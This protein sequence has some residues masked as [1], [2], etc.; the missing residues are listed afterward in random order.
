MSLS[1]SLH[2]AVGSEGHL[3]P[4][5]SLRMNLCKFLMQFSALS[6][7]AKIN[8]S[9]QQQSVIYIIEVS[10]SKC[11]HIMRGQFPEVSLHRG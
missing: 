6:V 8:I 3:Q 5:H 4:Q 11:V 1:R 7:L 9:G 10:F 2:N